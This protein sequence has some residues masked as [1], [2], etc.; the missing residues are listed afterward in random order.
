MQGLT[1]S[2]PGRGK[3]IVYFM[4]H[5]GRNIGH[6][7]SRF[8]RNWLRGDTIISFLQ[9]RRKES[10]KQEDP[11]DYCLK[12]RRPNGGVGEGGGVE[13]WKGVGPDL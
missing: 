8:E 6:Q 2:K 11:T 7:C 1:I 10:N 5:G 13:H 4:T 9:N 3:I 12:G